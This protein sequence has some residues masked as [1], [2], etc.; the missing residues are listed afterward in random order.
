MCVLAAQGRNEPTIMVNFCT[1]DGVWRTHNETPAAVS[2]HDAY[3]R[4]IRET[5]SRVQQF[6]DDNHNEP[7]VSGD[8]S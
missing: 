8:V 7:E 5:E 1:E 6:Y 3:V 2:D 4:V